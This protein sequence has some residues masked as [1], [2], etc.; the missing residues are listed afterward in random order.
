MVAPL[1]RESSEI[2]FDASQD[3]ELREVNKDSNETDNL[4]ASF[5]IDSSDKTDDDENNAQ[6]DGRLN[7]DT[8]SD[9]V[10]AI[11]ERINRNLRN[12][13]SASSSTNLE[14]S[15]ITPEATNN[16]NNDI[17]NNTSR[18]KKFLTF[19]SIRNNF[20]FLDRVY[21]PLPVNRNIDV[22]SG[23]DG[24]FSNLSAKPDLSSAPVESDK[25]PTYD[26]VSQDQTPPYWE[27][28]VISPGF[29]DEVFIDGLPVGNIVNFVWNFLVSS[30]FQFVGFL[31][32]YL[33]H[34]SHAAKHGSRAGLGVT[35]ITYGY[36]MLPARPKSHN[37]DHSL[38]EYEIQPENPNEF[39]NVAVTSDR[40]EGALD[41]FTS[42]LTSGIS[43]PPTD[44][45]KSP[46]LTFIGIIVILMGVFIFVRAVL[47]YHRAKKMEE[48]ILQPP[49]TTLNTAENQV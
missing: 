41:Q 49:S 13:P 30:S 28:S 42:Q 45:T 46:H 31:L 24:V 19:D 48:V 43:A 9:E 16:D 26:E 15:A 35:F 47:N 27:N 6:K 7:T 8:N 29:M 10:I 22:G 32:T 4:L 1:P 11:H 40:V 20:N 3:V 17:F 2:L 37:P 33:L 44:E 5:E 38:Q 21:K 34:T 12:Q 25:P 36:V 18:I 14:A 39:N 23:S